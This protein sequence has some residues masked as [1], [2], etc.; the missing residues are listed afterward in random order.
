MAQNSVR[1][2]W[3]QLGII[4]YT[5]VAA[6]ALT[7]CLDSGGGGGG[8]PVSASGGSA[9]GSGAPSS[10]IG[11]KLVETFET[12]E[13][14]QGNREDL[15]LQSPGSTATY[16]FVDSQTV[17]GEGA[18]RTLPTES[19]TYNRV[20]SNKAVVE[21]RYSNG[22][23][24]RDELTFTRDNGGTFVTI[25]EIPSVGARVRYTGTFRTESTDAASGGGTSSDSGGSGGG[26]GSGSSGDACPNTET[27]TVTFWV[28]T[29]QAVGSV[30]VQLDGIG[31]R[32]S[33]SYFSGGGPEC[34]STGSGAMTFSDIPAGTYQW[35]AEDSDRGTWG[36]SSVRV[37]DACGCTRFELR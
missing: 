16:Q 36:P 13:V 26:S 1:V 19:W 23:K 20:G 37:P 29:S 11:V 8:T 5:A 4:L 32:T 7:A 21:L 34:G 17:L 33:S 24:T 35:S 27:G 9:G 28:S 18:I 25:A 2:A 31:A 6:F 10:I 14:L 22:G 30:R 3:K 12:S 15:K